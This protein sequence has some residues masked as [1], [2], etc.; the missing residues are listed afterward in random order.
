[1]ASVRRQSAGT[2]SP[3]LKE[4]MSP[5]TSSEVSTHDTG[6]IV[7]RHWNAAILQGLGRARATDQGPADEHRTLKVAENLFKCV[8]RNL[9]S[10]NEEDD[11]F[12]VE[13]AYTSG[14]AGE[15]SHALSHGPGWLG[16]FSS[17]KGCFE[18]TIRVVG[19]EC[20]DHSWNNNVA[21]YWGCLS[22]GCRGR[23]GNKR[24]R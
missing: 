16:I 5:D 23:L 15:D 10:L 6:I 2:I 12:V 18:A 1:M 9:S 7:M 4:T 13:F 24:E 8:Y 3:I 20:C 11:L 21:N 14:G 17:W 22:D 19:F